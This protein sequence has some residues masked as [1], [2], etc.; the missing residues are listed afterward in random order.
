VEFGVPRDDEFNKEEMEWTV[1][2]SGAKAAAFSMDLIYYYGDVGR[3]KPV[4]NIGIR[5]MQGG[6]E[7]IERAEK[8]VMEKFEEVQE[9][10]IRNKVI[11]FCM[12]CVKEQPD[13]I[14]I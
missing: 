7:L 14:S 9:L 13:E 10:L 2:I 6:R 4:L 12:A 5:E 3:I 11:F 1:R 8:E